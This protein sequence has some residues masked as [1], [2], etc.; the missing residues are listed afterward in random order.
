MRV[1]YKGSDMCVL[2]FAQGRPVA[3]TINDS[4]PLLKYKRTHNYKGFDLTLG[5]DM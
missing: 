2:V 5:F 3:S 1:L 4:A